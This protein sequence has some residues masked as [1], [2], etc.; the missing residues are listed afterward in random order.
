MNQKTFL[1]LTIKYCPITKLALIPFEK[2]PEKIYRGFEL[3]YLNGK[4]TGVG[5]RVLGY[6]TDNYV[7]VYDDVSL[8]FDPNETF[9]VVENGA[10]QHVQTQIDQV[11]FQKNG[12]SQVLGFSFTDVEGRKINFY[13]EEKTNRGSIALNLLAP[14]G[15][16]SKEPTFLP[17][18]F[19][20][21]FDFMRRK[22]QV[23]CTIDGNTIELD[24]FPFPMGGQ[25][26]SFCRYSNTCELLE[27]ANTESATLQQVTLDDQMQYVD[28]QVT[29]KITYQFQSENVLESINVQLNQGDILT[30]FTPALNLNQSCNGEFII[31][32]TERMGD[33][34]GHFDVVVDGEI[35]RL[36]LVPDLGWRSVPTSLISRLIMN[37][38]SVFCS[39]SKRYEYQ[40]EIQLR[41]MQINA[42]W[43]N[44]NV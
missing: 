20:Y 32:P 21:D 15:L 44:H 13:Y 35:A 18:F 1:P 25:R 11:H 19:M 43:I 16:G 31:A 23:R 8:L 38:K 4:R 39:W 5:Y 10:N 40:A 6:R 29:S 22:G 34:R 27:F 12:K 36:K 37:K 9:N 3:Q 42:K 2:K 26:R 14:V 41:K 30:T 7:D 17:L 24:R 28:D 33:I